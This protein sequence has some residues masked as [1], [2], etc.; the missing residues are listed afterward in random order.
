VFKRGKLTYS[1]KSEQCLSFV[2]VMIMKGLRETPG[3]LEIYLDLPGN[4]VGE[5][6]I[7]K[8]FKMNI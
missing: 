5:K 3:L 4:M 6:K 2:G 7:Q 8:I 1:D